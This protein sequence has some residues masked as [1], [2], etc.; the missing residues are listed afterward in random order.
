MAFQSLFRTTTALKIIPADTVIT[1]ATVPTV[2][3]W[4][5]RLYSAKQEELISFSGVSGSTITG[6]VRNLSLTANPATAWTGLTWVAWTSCELVIMHDQMID[7]V[8]WWTYTWPIVYDGDVTFNNPV[9]FTE[10]F[11][12]PVYANAAARDAAIPS[13][14]NGMSVYLTA[15]WYFTDY[16]AWAW[17]SRAAWAATVNASTTVAGKVELPTTAETQS[18]TT[19]WWTWASLTLTL[20]Q[21]WNYYSKWDWSDGNVTISSNTSLTRDM[22]Y[23]NLTVNT[24]IVLDPAGYAVYVAWTLTLTWTAKIARN[25][26]NWWNATNSTG[27]T[28]AAALASWTCWTC[29]WWV[30]G[31]TWTNLAGWNGTNWTWTSGSSYTAITSAAWWSGWFGWAWWGTWGTWATSAQWV[32][33]NRLYSLAQ[34]LSALMSPSRWIFST[35]AYGWTPGAWSWAAWWGN[36]W[37]QTG[38]G[39]GWSGWSWG[40]IFIYANIIAGSWTIEAKWGTWGN[41]GVWSIAIAWG[42]GWGGGWSGWVVVLVYNSGTPYTIT[43]TWWAAWTGWAWIWWWA[44]AWSNWAAWTAWTSIV[45]NK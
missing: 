29:E 9:V 21:F 36:G 45:I 6:C 23:N 27:W 10:S 5:I 42:G 13:P 30:V 19:T 2:T 24:G 15:E 35:A 14:T 22:F 18:L 39:G 8:V 16:Q 11:K 40:N 41:W 34:A 1:L 4:R 26:N 25:G 38:W 7:P 32:R 44:T 31:T 3:S 17:S 43:V 37:W 20:D 33:Y 28:A 12:E